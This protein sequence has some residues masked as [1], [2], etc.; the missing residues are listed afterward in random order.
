MRRRA[1]VAR[2]ALLKL[3][4]AKCS[5][6]VAASSA[7]SADWILA[8]EP[9]AASATVCGARAAAALS[10]RP[11]SCSSS[12]TLASS[13]AKPSTASVW[14]RLASALVRT[15]PACGRSR[16]C[17][18]CQR[19]PSGRR[20]RLSLPADSGITTSRVSGSPSVRERTICGR[21][22]GGSSAT[23]PRARAR[24]CV[25]CLTIAVETRIIARLIDRRLSLAGDAGGAS[26]SIRP[27]RFASGVRRRSEAAPPGRAADVEEFDP[28]GRARC[29][30]ARPSV[31]PHDR[32][33]KTCR[34]RSG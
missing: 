4:S 28:L 21:I 6:S 3:G 27:G 19:S 7:S 16:A 25:P 32:T 26:Y 14:R 31:R 10:I 11:A 18:A 9:T 34:H 22:A 12:K 33:A 17:S 24:S 1:G 30:V 13:G 15:V 20:A 2:P 29:G 5:A 23:G 8:G